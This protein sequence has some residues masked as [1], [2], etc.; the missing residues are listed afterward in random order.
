M[1]TAIFGTNIGVVLSAV[2]AERLRSKSEFPR[3][4]LERRNSTSN[5][6]RVTRGISQQKNQV[7]DPWTSGPDARPVIPRSGV[8][9]VRPHQNVQFPVGPA[10]ASKTI[11]VQWTW[12]WRACDARDRAEIFVDGPQV[13]I[14]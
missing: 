1:L 4:Q 2:F 7:S 6:W 10:S 11:V 12:C 8:E 5:G 14:R 3:T 9:S 13:M